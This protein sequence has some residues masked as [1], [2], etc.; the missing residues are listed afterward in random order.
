MPTP[1]NE[2]DAQFVRGLSSQNTKFLTKA[3]ESACQPAESYDHESNVIET[4]SMS[5]GKRN[6]IDLDTNGKD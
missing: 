4:D 1:L 5:H 3:N 2:Q 6:A